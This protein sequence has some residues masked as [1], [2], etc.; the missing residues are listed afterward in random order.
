MI[1]ET[2]RRAA[3]IATGH[4]HTLP[5]LSLMVHSSCNCRCVMCDIWKANALKRE[6]TVDALD[7]HMQAIRRLH[8]GSTESKMQVAECTE[9]SH[10]SQEGIIAEAL[11][12][13]PRQ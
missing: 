7:A 8:V 5:V 3:G 13:L 1:L 11:Q 6:M 4:V 10:F 2:A 9:T 12:S